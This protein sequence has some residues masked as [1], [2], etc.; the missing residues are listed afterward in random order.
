VWVGK[1]IHGMKS[2]TPIHSVPEP[3]QSAGFLD[4]ALSRIDVDLFSTLCFMYQHFL[5]K[6]KAGACI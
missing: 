1:N 2:V 6:K 5:G 3:W 4:Q